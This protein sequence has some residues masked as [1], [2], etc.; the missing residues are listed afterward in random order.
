MTI[1]GYLMIDVYEGS[2][3]A[4]RFANFINRLLPLIDRFP[5]PK[6]VILLDNASSH[7]SAIKDPA[8]IAKLEEAGVRVLWLPPYSLDF[9]P[10]EQ[11]FNELKT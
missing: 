4:Q 1:N 6:L 7:Q 8:M 9:N 11:S 5:E 2:Y 3:N 10:I